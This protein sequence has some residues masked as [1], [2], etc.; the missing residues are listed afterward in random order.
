[1][2]NGS[3]TNEL[4][5]K[6]PQWCKPKEVPFG[7]LRPHMGQGNPTAQGC[8]VDCPI[9][10][11]TKKFRLGTPWEMNDFFQNISAQREGQYQVGENPYRDA[12]Y[13]RLSRLFAVTSRSKG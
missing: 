11:M 10:G 3:I 12:S 13:Q 2:Q 6:V 9:K 8:G 4:R 5:V 7:S 1:M